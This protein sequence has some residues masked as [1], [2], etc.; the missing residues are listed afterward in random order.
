MN[1]LRS[2]SFIHDDF[3]LESREASQLYHD[4]AKHLPIIDYHNHLSAEDIANNQPLQN[5][6]RA[7]LS[8]DHYKWRAMRANGVPERFITG[9]AANQE[10]FEK[11]AQTVPHT[12]R[13]PLY[14]WTHLELKRY[15]DIDKLLNKESAKFIYE[16]TNSRLEELTPADLLQKMNVEV[17]CTTNGPLEDLSAHIKIAGDNFGFEVLPTFRSDELFALEHKSFI[18]FK[19]KLEK[20]VSFDIESLSDFTAAIDK[21]I[22]F[23]HEQ[24]CRLSD[25]GMGGKLSFVSF[26]HEEIDKIFSNVLNGESPGTEEIDKYR[27]FLF[28]YLGKKY[29]EKSW[30]Q[31][32]HLGAIRNNNSRL[33]EE[34]GNDVGCDSIGDYSLS[35]FLSKFLDA[36]DRDNKLTRTIAYNLNP[37]QNEV[38]ASMLGNFND[39]TLAG[40]MQWGAA[41]WF[42]DQK[43]GLEK[44][45]D[46][47]S[48]LGLLSR[49]IGMVTDSRSFLSFPRH[50]YFRR[51][52]CN[53]LAQDLKKGLIPNDQSLLKE[54]IENVCYTN[55]RQYFGFQPKK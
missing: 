49:F 44:H 12:L 29:H 36:L 15:F 11:W 20:V 52:L 3:L 10:K 28:I 4:Y 37:S 39:G 18:D 27:S 9:E 2:T 38:F 21:R 25:F 8:E 46:A 51:V 5:I 30:A 33:R 50:E 22:D 55:A 41:W 14:H 43:D 16:E 17:V 34:V 47:V 32:Y 24:G 26:R 48:N 7:W 40:K 19:G 45:L 31:Q 1:D 23:F 13:N 6:T 53:V 54:I 35:E 42:L